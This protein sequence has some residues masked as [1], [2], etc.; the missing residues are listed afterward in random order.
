MRSARTPLALAVLLSCASMT[1]AA[2]TGPFSQ[3]VNF[4]DSLSDAGNFPDLASPLQ[5]GLPTGGLR[6]TNRTG[7][8][9]APNNTEYAGQVVTQVLADRL[10]LQSLPSTPLLPALLTGNPDGTNY[11]VGGYRSDQILDSLNDRSIV[12]TGTGLSRSRPGYLVEN[13]QVDPN[14]LYYL[15]G[16][17]NDIFQLVEG[18]S[19]I[20]ITMAQS[21]ANMV[22][23]VGAL[24]AA[25]ARYIVISDLPDV[26]N[27][28]LGNSLPGFSTVLNDLSDTFNAEL[29][30]GLQAQGGNY[31]LLNNRL[32]LSEVRADLA[33]YGFDP[34]IDQT[35]VCFD[36]GN[37]PL[38]PNYGLGTANA[39]PSRL[40]FNDQVHPTTAV[41]QIS[42]DYI[43]SIL[44][45]PAEVS[46]L[47]EMGRSALRNHLQM[48][49]NELTVQRGNWQSIGAWRTF[50]QGGYNS[51]EYDGFGGGDGDNPTLAIGAT[52]RVSDN[53][54]AGLSLGLGQNSLTL[55]EGDSDY[56]M[57]SYLATAFASFQQERL[58][59]DFSVS[60]GYLDYDDLERTFA[61][62]VAE[63]SEK[64]S[65]EGML[66]GV[67]GKTGFNL[68]QQGERL[69]FGP[70][71]G[72]SYQK[73]EVDGYSEK[74]ASATALTY[75]DQELDSLRLSLGLFGGY[76]LTERTRLFGEVAREVERKDDERDDLRMSLNSVPN[77]S[78]ELPGATP[79]GDQTRFSVG[80]AHQL[81]AGLSVR[82]NYNY[83]GNDNR[84]HGIGLSLAL[85]L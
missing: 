69:Q 15:N 58:F 44:S 33:R 29:S 21:A 9:Y 32:L 31:V 50:V 4:G 30:A 62:G 10:G 84:N 26:G 12:D 48:L 25:G 28:P 23:A 7:P 57:R 8:T 38:D 53:W 71:I 41:H 81:T 22:A 73:I 24:Q 80:V 61:L 79:T 5:N 82:A 66:W 51:P 27:T 2:D 39:D 75:E 19:P 77:N 6:F 59:A 40:L 83:Q 56:D 85:D 13:P 78:F 74:G 3:F 63:R 42:A 46:R 37:C 43:Y 76:A 67:S 47:P 70:F 11:A 45:A 1:A 68:M 34:T 17:A 20:P 72:A 55:G 16:G 65:T 54:L 35:A 36:G 52:N 18:T 64:G 49:D 14:G 60:A